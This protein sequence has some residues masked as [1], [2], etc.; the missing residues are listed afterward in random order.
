[1]ETDCTNPG[2]LCHEV[3]PKPAPPM[4]RENTARAMRSVDSKLNIVYDEI[5]RLIAAGHRD[6]VGVRT[7]LYR[8]MVRFGAV[9]GQT[10][11]RMG[12]TIKKGIGPGDWEGEQK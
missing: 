8:A 7:N 11:A 2:C 12:F 9:H 1:M 6:L 4:G 10:A 3:K 5:D